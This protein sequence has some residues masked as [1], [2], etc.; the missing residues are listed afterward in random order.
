MKSPTDT[1]ERLQT[2]PN[3]LVEPFVP[4]AQQHQPRRLRQ[5]A[6][7]RLVEPPAL[8]GK[9]HQP[10]LRLAQRLHFLN[11]IDDWLTAQKHARSASVGLVVDRLMLVGRPIAEVPAV[12][13][14]ET[15]LDGLL[16]QTLLKVALEEIGEEGEDVEAHG[17]AMTND[18]I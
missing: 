17:R 14:D 6:D 12:H 5:L 1:S 11:A 13:L 2:K 10:S 7:Q 18:E 3:P 8:R 15:A 4:A 9:H 16:Q